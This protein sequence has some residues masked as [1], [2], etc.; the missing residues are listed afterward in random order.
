MKNE[1]NNIN[2]QNK[3]DYQKKKAEKALIKAKE[4]EALQLSNGKHYQ[5]INSKTY[6]LM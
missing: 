2:E 6:I 5:R 3:V 1:T 4:V